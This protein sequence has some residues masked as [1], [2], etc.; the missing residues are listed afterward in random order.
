MRRPKSFPVL[1]VAPNVPVFDLA[2]L[3]ALEH[4][5]F[6]KHGLA[7]EFVGKHDPVTS[8]R[9]VFLRQKESL[10]DSCQADAYDLCEWAGLDRS[11]RSKRG[12]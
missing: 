8:D 9:D 7:I 5:L 10:Y 6:E 4:G 3:V 1:R 12:S 2:I 11:D